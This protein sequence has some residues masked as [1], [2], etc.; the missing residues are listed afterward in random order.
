MVRPPSRGSTHT[1]I[2]LPDSLFSKVSEGSE[3]QSPISEPDL[4]SSDA[5]AWG[6]P[7]WEKGFA[8]PLG[9]SN[10]LAPTQREQPRFN[11]G[12]RLSDLCVYLPLTPWLPQPYPTTERHALKS[13]R[14]VTPRPPRSCPYRMQRILLWLKRGK[15]Q[16]V[17]YAGPQAHWHYP[18]LS[19]DRSR[20]MSRHKSVTMQNT[21]LDKAVSASGNGWVDFAG[22]THEY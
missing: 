17:S 9:S 16:H 15:I 1:D 11:T 19:R 14:W 4:T 6:G 7:Y 13:R 21:N 20:R 2:S 3:I 5:L 12:E 10:E 8:E 18:I 22:S